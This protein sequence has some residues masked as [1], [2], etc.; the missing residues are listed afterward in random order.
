MVNTEVLH[1]DDVCIDKLRGPLQLKHSVN[2]PI[3]PALKEEFGDECFHR[4]NEVSLPPHTL[5]LKIGMPVMILRNLEPPIKCNG[6]KARITRIGQHVLEAEIVGGKRE[7]LKI[8]IPRI[9]LQSKDDES[10]KGRRA[11]VPCHFTRRQ[12]PIR[13]AFAMTINKLQG[14]SLRHAGV[15]V[16]VRNCFTHG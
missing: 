1:I 12:V 16:Q 10:S 3:N 9:P 14:Q 7:G 11:I 5:R 4:Y 6:T 13:P 15:D 8:L 2:T